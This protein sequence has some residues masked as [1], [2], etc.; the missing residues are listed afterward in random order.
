MSDIKSEINS[1]PA[2]VSIYQI[3]KVFYYLI[4]LYKPEINAFPHIHTKIDSI[5]DLKKVLFYTLLTE[6]KSI[7]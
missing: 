6:K 4:I 5:L 2:N 1:L 3:N 7:F